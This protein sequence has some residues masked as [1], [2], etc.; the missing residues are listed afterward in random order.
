MAILSKSKTYLDCHGNTRKI[1]NSSGGLVLSGRQDLMIKMGVAE[2]QKF[3]LERM[4]KSPP[5]LSEL[6]EVGIFFE[7]PVELFYDE[8]KNM[9][10]Y[11][12]KPLR[13]S[14]DHIMAFDSIQFQQMS[15]SWPLLHRVVG[16]IAR[17]FDFLQCAGYRLTFLSTKTLELSSVG[18][19]YWSAM[20]QLLLDNQTQSRSQVVSETTDPESL[21]CFK[22]AVIL[23]QGLMMGRHPF[24]GKWVLAGVK[25][26]RIKLVRLGLFPWL[27][28]NHLY[29]RPHE[30][31]PAY[32]ALHPE[33]Q[34][35]FNSCFTL[36][37][38]VSDACPS[39]EVWQYVLAK[40]IPELPAKRPKGKLISSVVAPEL[41]P[42][43]LEG[44]QQ[45]V[46]PPLFSGLGRKISVGLVILLL[47]LSLLVVLQPSKPVVLT[48]TTQVESRRIEGVLLDTVSLISRVV[49]AF[50][51][52]LKSEKLLISSDSLRQKNFSSRY[53][54]MVAED[55]KALKSAR[56]AYHRLL[57][58]Y[59]NGVRVL[60]AFQSVKVGKIMDILWQQRRSATWRPAL[61]FIRDDIQGC[62]QLNGLIWMD[63]VAER[64]A[65][66]AKREMP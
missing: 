8:N 25:P 17:T 9:V 2:E 14:S 19:L 27:S 34:R 54:A 26:E 63:V 36:G 66:L 6:E 65:V 42:G 33:L 20:D 7:W 50:H 39:P 51:G 35:Q 37:G 45:L 48:P 38:Q 61:D 24:D 16:K 3:I 5:P 21:D 58:E 30:K 47:V 62:H 22:L 43:Q 4:V 41:L 44:R 64:F 55:E 23:F 12:F 46:P 40:L 57:V 59:Q 31:H 15:W 11:A 56:E 18:D 60:C 32:G 13:S 53:E 52:V 10:G 29:I 49:N 28:R 1:E